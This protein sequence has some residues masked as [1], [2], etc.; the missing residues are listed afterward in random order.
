MIRPG[1]VLVGTSPVI[2]LV[3]EV[4]TIPDNH[5]WLKAVM[6]RVYSNVQASLDV[7]V[8]V[9]ASDSHYFNIDDV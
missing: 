1:D 8:Y 4:R 7:E 6:L 3:V 5:D 9:R 2:H